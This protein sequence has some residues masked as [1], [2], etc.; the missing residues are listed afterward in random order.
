MIISEFSNLLQLARS[1]AERKSELDKSY[2]EN[3]IAPAW[4]SFTRVHEDYLFSYDKYLKHVTSNAYDVKGLIESVRQD[5]FRTANLRAELVAILKNLPPS[6]FAVGEKQL[7][8]FVK[9]I[10]NYFYVSLAIK[11]EKRDNEEAVVLEQ[12]KPSNNHRYY[13]VISL[14]RNGV[15]DKEKI[16]YHIEKTI[17]SLQ[18][19]YE[20]IANRYY[21][22]KKSLLA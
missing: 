17:L 5:S 15:N 21:Y 16:K 19:G 2:F 3:F 6:S 4:N 8:E 1:L 13:L 14:S 20:G 9:A 7:G 18:K 10:R 22:L 11:Y 12:L